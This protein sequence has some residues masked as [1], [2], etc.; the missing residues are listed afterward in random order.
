LSSRGTGTRGISAE[1]PL[2][3]SSEAS[4]A[5]IGGLEADCWSAGRTSHRLDI[6]VWLPR[7][8]D[9]FRMLMP[10]LPIFDVS[11]IGICSSVVDQ[12]LCFCRRSEFV[13]LCQPVMCLLVAQKEVRT[14]TSCEN[15][16]PLLHKECNSL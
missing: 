8:P 9:F 3:S 15:L 10:F 16:T 5:A 2:A 14:L 7:V 4:S 6:H 11:S 12:N 13:L 1:S